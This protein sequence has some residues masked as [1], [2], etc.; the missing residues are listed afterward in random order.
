MKKTL[1]ALVAFVCMTVCYSLSVHAD[2]ETCTM[3]VNG[4]GHCV[5]IIENG[6]VKGYRCDSG[7][8][9]VTCNK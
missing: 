9:D 1:F 5:K 8:G 4:S 7:S 6:T 2:S 3:E